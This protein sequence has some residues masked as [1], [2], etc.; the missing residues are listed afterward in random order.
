[1]TKAGTYSK[2]TMSHYPVPPRRSPA[3]R[4]IQLTSYTEDTSPVDYICALERTAGRIQ[5]AAVQLQNP[6][7]AEQAASPPLAHYP[8]SYSNNNQPAAA[9]T[10]KL[11]FTTPEAASTAYAAVAESITTNSTSSPVTSPY[12]MVPGG[13]VTAERLSCFVL[14][15]GDIFVNPRDLT[16]IARGD[17]SAPT[18][19][20]QSGSLSSNSLAPTQS[21]PIAAPVGA[22][23][24]TRY[25]RGDVLNSASPSTT[26]YSTL[27]TGNSSTLYSQ[28]NNGMALGLGYEGGHVRAYSFSSEDGGYTSSSSSLVSSTT[29]SSN[30]RTSPYL[31]HLR[32]ASSS[33]DTGFGGPYGHIGYTVGNSG[34]FAMGDRGVSIQTPGVL[35]D[36]DALAL[37][38]SNLDVA[39]PIAGTNKQ[40][41]PWQLDIDLDRD[42]PRRK[43]TLKPAPTPIVSAEE[44]D[45]VNQPA[46][47]TTFASRSAVASY[48]GALR[49]SL[50]NE[51]T[52]KNSPVVNVSKTSTVAHH[53]HHHSDARSESSSTTTHTKHSTSSSS[54]TK[55]RLANTAHHSNSS[56]GARNNASHPS[57]G[58]HHRKA[59]RQDKRLYATDPHQ[60]P[61]PT[62]WMLSPETLASR[63]AR[64]ARFAEIVKLGLA[65][66]RTKAG[67]AQARRPGKRD[68]DAAKA[69]L[70]E[71]EE[72]KERERLRALLG[73]DEK[74]LTTA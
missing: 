12:P 7:Q 50:P 59:P 53:H 11:E 52:N 65:K 8:P 71:M 63:E 22:Q 35:D 67:W 3:T 28:M 2:E 25:S 17:W 23:P 54:S 55:S 74:K 34:R 14:E 16:N 19:H 32:S 42:E 47:T 38:M 27:R 1:M 46:T 15:D 9:W 62:D 51:T 69:K 5:R 72:E 24:S 44:K 61:R 66:G 10:L 6:R 58:T 20:A 33:L 57:S 26:A 43:E 29:A 41:A 31:S 70:R 48:S 18:H 49:K 4:S 39:T 73:E 21:L 56:P 60:G 30:E 13:F 45:S 68:R 36:F 37:S 40:P 64:D